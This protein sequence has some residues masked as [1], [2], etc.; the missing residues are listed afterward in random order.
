MFNTELKKIRLSLYFT[1]KEFAR[2]IDIPL[3]TYKGWERGK[4]LPT[5][6]HFETLCQHLEKRYVLTTRLKKY[7]VEGK[8][9]NADAKV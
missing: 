8:T 9:A 5:P 4:Q 2:N 7:Y 3:S 6:T 1:Q